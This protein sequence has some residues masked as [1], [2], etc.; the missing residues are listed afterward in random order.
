MSQIV[1][2]TINSEYRDIAL[3]G[4]ILKTARRDSREIEIIFRGCRFLRSQAIVGLKAIQLLAE[5]RRALVTYDTVD[6]S[7]VVLRHLERSGV[8][9][10]P[11]EQPAG[12]TIPVRHFRNLESAPMAIYLRDEWLGRLPFPLD[13]EYQRS[14]TSA[15][16]EIF[17]NV[18]QHSQSPIG[19]VVGGQLFP[20]M[21]QLQLTVIDLGI[22][23]PNSI[24]RR[25]PQY[26]WFKADDALKFAFKPGYS[27]RDAPRGLGLARLRNFVGQ[28]NGS[29]R[30]FSDVGYAHLGSSEYFGSFPGFP[31][32]LVDVT[33]PVASP[34]RRLRTPMEVIL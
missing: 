5:R 28:N 7:T 1:I 16:C 23:I 24:R 31:G 19:L 11:L 25:L 27:S 20:N 8:R 9:E 18:F 33:I 34:F 4:E 22:G 12:T 32:T 30:V 17:D 13:P 26:G 10:S 3:L 14:I 2:P 15:V 21:K 6:C 29:L